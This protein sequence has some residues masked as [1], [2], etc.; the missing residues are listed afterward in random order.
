[1][2]FLIGGTS[3]AGLAGSSGNAGGLRNPDA[4]VAHPLQKLEPDAWN[5]IPICL[6]KAVKMLI[7]SNIATDQ[8]MRQLNGSTDTNVRKLNGQLGKLE[9]D[10]LKKE[11][12]LK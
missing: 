6:V 4:E 8:K 2:Q 7:E 11:E 12:Q 1:M 10:L 5:N 9:K 3:G